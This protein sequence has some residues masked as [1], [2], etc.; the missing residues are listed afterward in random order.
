MYDISKENAETKKEIDIRGR[1]IMLSCDIEFALFNIMMYCHP[2]PYNHTREGT[3]SKMTMGGKVFNVICDI[4]KY[5]PDYY[6]EFKES[7]DALEEFTNVRNDMAHC[8]G[9]FPNAPDLSVF[10]ILFMTPQ[11]PTDKTNKKEAIM[12]REYKDSDILALVNK[13]ASINN[14]LGS[15][16]LRLKWEFETGGGTHPFLHPSTHTS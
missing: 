1:F 15:L 6:L 14:H 11:D 13:F 10:R 12:F 9:I 2:D 4:K 8:K 5:K 16:M 7:F 3:F